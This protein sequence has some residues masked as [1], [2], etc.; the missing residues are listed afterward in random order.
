M[1]NDEVSFVGAFVRVDRV[2]LLST[3]RGV[4]A[5]LSVD[6]AP[7]VRHRRFG[8]RRWCRRGD[9]P[10]DRSVAARLRR[11]YILPVTT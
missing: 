9:R 10:L 11:Q 1:V 6:R 5:A 3:R 2:R 7:H 8:D 4:L